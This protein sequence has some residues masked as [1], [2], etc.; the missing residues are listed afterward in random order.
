MLKIAQTTGFVHVTCIQNGNVMFINVNFISY[1][2]K[3][4]E[5]EHKRYPCN[6]T[7]ICPNSTSAQNMSISLHNLQKLQT[8]NKSVELSIKR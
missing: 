7:P 2:N 5:G 1:H 8:V 3:I 4:S 6:S